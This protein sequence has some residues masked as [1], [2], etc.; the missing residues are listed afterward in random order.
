MVRQQWLMLAQA[1]AVLIRGDHILGSSVHTAWVQLPGRQPRCACLNH[2]QQQ[3]SV[4]LAGSSSL[5]GGSLQHAATHSGS[6]IRSVSLACG[7]QQ[8][9]GWQ[10]IGATL[11]PIPGRLLVHWAHLALTSSK[12]PLDAALQLVGCGLEEEWPRIS[13][14]QQLLE[15][16]ERKV[17]VGL[18][19]VSLPS[20]RCHDA[21]VFH[22]SIGEAS[23]SHG[24]AHLRCASSGLIIL[25]VATRRLQC[26]SRL[27]FLCSQLA[28]QAPKKVV[29][30]LHCCLCQRRLHMHGAACQRT[31]HPN[32]QPETD[33]RYYRPLESAFW[34]VLTLMTQ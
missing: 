17:V 7:M 24:A 33:E 6:G 26:C 31:M 22:T 29:H 25:A 19:S 4:L 15:K 10:A 34:H 32:R 3:E 16:L 1:P 11:E 30:D 20:T 12:H 23:T 27:P 9:H 18:A 5:A 8:C 28:D 21:F 13:A 2:G 14:P